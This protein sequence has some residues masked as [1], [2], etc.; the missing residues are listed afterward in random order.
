MGRSGWTLVLSEG[1]LQQRRQVLWYSVSKIPQLL[2]LNPNQGWDKLSNPMTEHRDLVWV[3]KTNQLDWCVKTLPVSL[4]C[5]V[6][7]HHDVLTAVDGTCLTK[8]MKKPVSRAD[9]TCGPG[10]NQQ[11]I[12]DYLVAV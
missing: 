12:S 7:L 4:F 6:N 5:I 10:S 8:V 9:L 3:R 2:A 1:E 11:V